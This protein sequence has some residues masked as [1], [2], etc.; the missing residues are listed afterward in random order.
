MALV[1]ANIAF[2]YHVVYIN[3]W[4]TEEDDDALLE[5]EA[6]EKL[7]EFVP[8]ITDLQR[9]YIKSAIIDIEINR[10]EDWSEIRNRDED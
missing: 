8:E 2:D 9:D 7:L 5:V 10:E 1:S 6:I 3:A 4:E